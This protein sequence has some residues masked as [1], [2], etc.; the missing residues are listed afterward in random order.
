MC[1][2]SGLDYD[3]LVLTLPTRWSQFEQLVPV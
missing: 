1:R 2:E 3:D